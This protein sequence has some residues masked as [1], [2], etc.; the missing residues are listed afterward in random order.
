MI[1]VTNIWKSDWIRMVIYHSTEHY[2]FIKKLLDLQKGDK[3]YP[4]I[5]LGECLYKLA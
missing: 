4:Q 1:M 3:Y 5:F 2:S